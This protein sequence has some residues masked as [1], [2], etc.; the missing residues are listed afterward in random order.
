MRMLQALGFKCTFMPQNLAWMGH[1]TR[2]LQRMG[3]E[4]QYPPFVKSFFEL[5]Q[6]RGHEFDIVYVTR[7]YVDQ[8][9]IEDIR[10]YAP[11]AQIILNNADLHLLREIRAAL[12]T[13]DR[14]SLQRATDTRE[15]EWGVMRDGDLV[16]S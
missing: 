12:L 2:N 14:A 6:S 5:L 16:F 15:A 7:F 4:V 3:V 1:Y 10:T 8:Q 13:S 9:C 11:R